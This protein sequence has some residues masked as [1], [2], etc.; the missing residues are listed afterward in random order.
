MV[1]GIFKRSAQAYADAGFA[2]FPLS[3]GSRIP[4]KDSHGFKDATRDPE[5]IKSWSMRYGFGNIAVRTGKEDNLTV[6]DIDRHPAKN[7]FD[8]VE[9]W[10]AEGKFLPDE[11]V[12]LT[13][14]NGE[15]HWFQ[16]CPELDT[17]SDRLGL[18]IDVKNDNAGITAPPSMVGPKGYRWLYKA[19]D[20]QLPKVPQ[21]VIDEA[22]RLRAAKEA[23]EAARVAEFLA[24]R[25]G[26]TVD[27]AKL[28]DRERRRHLAN[29]RCILASKY[30]EL[31][32]MRRNSGRNTELYR[33]AARMGKY[34]HHGVM[35]DVEARTSLLHAAEKNR[36]VIDNGLKDVNDTINDGFQAAQGDSLP[37][38]IE[39]PRKRA[40]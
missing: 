32:K 34:I 15:H 30:I 6:I 27:V 11:A 28:S 35:T 3:V 37:E 39:R 21:W 18:G 13:P 36:L 40:A 29:A 14:G 2:V 8:L 23:S 17:G 10:Q 33:A 7:G 5:Q 22:L 20:G 16:Y 1:Q 25:S 26:K 31:T 19:K 38:L 9:K 12:A 4:V 24:K